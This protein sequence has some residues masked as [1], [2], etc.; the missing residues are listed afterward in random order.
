MNETYKL[1]SELIREWLNR[2]GRK[3]TYITT[4][5]NCSMGLV[6]LMLGKGHVPKDHT[7]KTLASLMGIKAKMLLIPNKEKKSA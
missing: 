1:N 2:E 6:D 7:L 3:K 4:Q 5:L